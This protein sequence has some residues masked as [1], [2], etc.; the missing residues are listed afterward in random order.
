MAVVVVVAAVV[1]VVAAAVA[2][3]VVAAVAAAAVAADN[4]VATL[5]RTELM[6]ARRQL[7]RPAMVELLLLLPMAQL[8]L[9]R[10][11]VQ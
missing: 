1:A 8:R 4:D 5:N 7:R 10:F 3:A 6:E 11:R 2:A 9:L